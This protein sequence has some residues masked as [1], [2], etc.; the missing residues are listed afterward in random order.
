MESQER[1]RVGRGALAVLAGTLP[2][3]HGAFF[4]CRSM[5]TTLRITHF[6]DG[7]LNVFP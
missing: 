4:M 2:C 5:W 6:A 7:I 3:R 1:Y